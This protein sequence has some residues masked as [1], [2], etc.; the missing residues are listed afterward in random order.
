[1]HLFEAHFANGGNVDI[2]LT[3]K[4][5]DEIERF[6][7][8]NE[9]YKAFLK[10]NVE[11]RTNDVKV[12]AWFN[13]NFQNWI[14]NEAAGYD[15]QNG[16]YT[17]EE[18]FKNLLY[19]EFNAVINDLVDEFPDI[20]Q[21]EFLAMF[22]DYIQKDPHSAF[23]FAGGRKVRMPRVLQKVT[24]ELVDYLNALTDNYRER[25]HDI[26]PSIYFVRD[27]AKLPPTV[28]IENARAYHVYLERMSE[29][30]SKEQAK[31]KFK[32]LQLGKDFELVKTETPLP[33]GIR[34][35]KALSAEFVKTEGHV[36]GHCVGTYANN[37]IHGTKVIWSL[38]DEEGLPVATLELTP[39]L[40]SLLQIKGKKN[41][42]IN[43]DYYDILRTIIFDKK[44][45]FQNSGY[46]SG[47]FKLM[48]LTNQDLN[49]DGT[50]KPLK[51]ED[52]KES[53]RA[54]FLNFMM[55]EDESPKREPKREPKQAPPKEKPR[56]KLDDIKFTNDDGK[57]LPASKSGANKE[58]PQKSIKLNTASA[59]DT[60]KAVKDVK[61]DMRSMLLNLGMDLSGLEDKIDKKYDLMI[62]TTTSL[63]KVINTA[64]KVAGKEEPKWHMVRNLPGYMS[65]GIRAIGRQVFSHFTSTPVEEIQT[66]AHINGGPNT[67]KEVNDVAGFL[68]KFGT[69]VN[70]AS[71]EFQGRIPGY[72][73][74]I[75]V[76]TFANYTFKLV[77]DHAG[78][79]IYAWPSTD[80]K[81]PIADKSLQIK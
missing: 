13:S 50:V 8:F 44:L 53:Y 42:Q 63:P 19:P 69:R 10:K 26:L 39:N 41:G 16:F 58:V 74:E 14:K 64:L 70:E 24:D 49:P 7:S 28:A 17:R 40:K 73:A 23:I 33:R 56:T 45:K 75:I 15:S 3:D 6:A 68:V 5:G 29:K 21:N 54:K 38:Q 57:N 65:Q 67:K 77:K 37:V 59:S 27:L 62:P 4:T 76:Y 12:R 66:I 81:K 31:Q 32:Q 43:P 1:M 18:Q 72:R 20:P 60:R 47:D 25:N 55:E 61:M 22:P 51:G 80:N 46:G 79:Y 71:V 52:V 78:E 9:I 36:M 2:V 35:V 34:L 30:V 48:G 11:P